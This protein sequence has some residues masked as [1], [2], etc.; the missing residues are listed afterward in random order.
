MVTSLA[1]WTNAAGGIEVSHITGSAAEGSSYIEVDSTKG[2]DRIEQQV[3]TTAG[4]SYR[5]SFSQS[6]RPGTSSATNRVDVF[7]NGTKLGTVSRNGVGLAAPSWQVTTY[8]VTG[9]GRDV[10][11]YRENDRDNVGGLLDNVRLVA[12]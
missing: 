11:S 9:T 2:H 3:T 6:P 8:T 10:I 1:G 5:L 12:L 7:F 4:R